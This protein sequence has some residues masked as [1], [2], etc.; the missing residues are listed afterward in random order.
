MANS[1]ISTTPT[2]DKMFPGQMAAFRAANEEQQRE[3]LTDARR[4]AMAALCAHDFGTDT[5]AVTRTKIQ[6][7]TKFDLNTDPAA[8]YGLALHTVRFYAPKVGVK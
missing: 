2:Y 5:E 3:L 7:A 8:A 6:F 1:I 4:A